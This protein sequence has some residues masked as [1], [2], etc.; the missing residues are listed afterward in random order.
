MSLTVRELNQFGSV[1]EL[2]VAAQFNL[3]NQFSF[4]FFK[5]T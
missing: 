4:W 3:T 1:C 2:S 5:Q